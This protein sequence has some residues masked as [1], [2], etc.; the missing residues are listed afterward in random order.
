MPTDPAVN[1]K[2]N[3]SGVLSNI[4]SR[5]AFVRLGFAT[6]FVT[7]LSTIEIPMSDITGDWRDYFEHQAISHTVH[8][9]T[10]AIH[11]SISKLRRGKSRE[12]LQARINALNK[13]MRDR[14]VQL[15]KKLQDNSDFT[16]LGL[17]LRIPFPLGTAAWLLG[18]AFLAQY[19]ARSRRR[20]FAEI[21]AAQ[22]PVTPDSAPVWLAPL[23]W[24][25]WLMT[26]RMR[27]ALRATGTTF[28]PGTVLL[29]VVTLA[30]LGLA[31]R[32][33]Y[34][35]LEHA[36]IVD[37]VSPGIAAARA[38]D[39]WF[40]GVMLGNDFLLFAWAVFAGAMVYFLILCSLARP[41]QTPSLDRRA[42]LYGLPLASAVAALSLSS[43]Y[44]STF[45]RYETELR[46]KVAGLI[47]R[48]K[49][50]TRR[51]RLQREDLLP[52]FYIN[53]R[54]KFIHFVTARR[55]ILS[56]TPRAAARKLE[57]LG[58]RKIVDAAWAPPLFGEPEQFAAPHL[59]YAFEQWALRT[60]TWNSSATHR[61]M[62]ADPTPEQCDAACEILFAGAY[63]VAYSHP[64]SSRRLLNLGFGIA[65]RYA[66]RDALKHHAA[67]LQSLSGSL[68]K[69]AS[70]SLLTTRA[71]LDRF[72]KDMLSEVNEMLAVL[73]G[74]APPAHLRGFAR[75]WTNPRHPARWGLP[76]GN[77]FKGPQFRHLQIF[78]G[79]TRATWFKFN[80]VRAKL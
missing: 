2:Q 28:A 53:T 27:T 20:S 8:S 13:T 29:S 61:A 47:R 12:D 19:T 66:R 55:R 15:R 16:L 50:R 57:P 3:V 38:L 65:L 35:A 24:E 10:Q 34:L 67:Q 42:L 30:C 76:E 69:A 54:T 68:E 46:E 72:L 31:G 49:K 33:A 64:A 62:E 58:T 11:N 25:R 44:A 9:T 6:L 63:R 37:Y 5:N 23:P 75:H 59:A 7:Y 21:E 45:A 80:P 26:P 36:S 48:T 60:F 51:R 74:A 1:D 32:V 39:P 17:D 71:S 77:S 52:G 4:A 70:F 41:A 78:V 22:H 18:A 79:G 56:L 43:W 73:S 14:Q 40:P